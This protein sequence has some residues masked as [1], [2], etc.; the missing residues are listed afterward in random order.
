M[1]SLRRLL[2]LVILLGLVLVSGSPLAPQASAQVPAPTVSDVPVR[3]PGHTVA[4]LSRATKV[5]RTA[6]AIT[7]DPSIT[8]TVVLKRTDEAG[9]QRFLADIEDPHSA[10][11]GKFLSQDE[12]TKRFGP[13]PQAYDETV[14]Y[15]QQQGL[16][17]VEGSANRLTLTVK[18]TRTQVEH[19]FSVQIG[20]YQLGN[21]SFY[22]NDQDPLVP[23]SMAQ[24]IQAVAGLTNL[25]QPQSN[26]QTID[27]INKKCASNVII[28]AICLAALRGGLLIL[29]GCTGVIF[30]G[31][32]IVAVALVFTIFVV[33]ALTTLG[34][35]PQSQGAGQQTPG[36]S[37]TQANVTGAGQKIGLL[38][39]DTFHR[40]DV[41]DWLTF[42]Q[43]PAAQIGQ[44]MALLSEKPVNGG[45]AAP[46]PGE[47]EV[48]LDIN[49]VQQ[50]APGANVV[51]YHAPGNTSFQT[52][53]NAMINDG[54]TVIS[55]SWSYCEDQTSLAD[56]QSLDAIFANASASGVS[57]VNAS[58][59]S[60][61]TCLDG[62]PNTIG[63]P[64]DA[65]HATA[66]GGT[67]MTLGTGFTYGTE[68]WWD[69]SH[70][71]PPT[72]QGGFG[73]SRFFPRPAYQNGLTSADN[74]LGAGCGGPC[75]PAERSAALSGECGRLSR[76]IR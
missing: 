31:F 49:M 75:G 57:I 34:V 55:N 54:D 60:G 46:G 66:V 63:V 4:V 22:A 10:N 26:K 24:H 39:Y 8:L 56:V 65:P 43:R 30:C 38:E 28:G 53:F 70:A 11:H 3:L 35:G 67:T 19:A 61:S 42:L 48:L 27:D 25:A 29:T 62:N 5:A 14:A 36:A 37:A 68:T 44:Q 2:V 74:A 16:T 50:T 9:F 12:I 58:G 21:R 52:M 71:T 76:T 69:G 72:G 20:D 40:S 45:V 7:A 32:A 73:V 64:A 51:V 15:L 18:G 33:G 6:S 59:D 41:S 17:L 47:S 13:S 1:A 23:G